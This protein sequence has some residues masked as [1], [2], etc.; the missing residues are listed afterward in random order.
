MMLPCARRADQ[1]VERTIERSRDAV[2][3]IEAVRWSPS[4]TARSVVIE[5]GDV[6]SMS[7]RGLD[8]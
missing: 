3:V 8:D 4:P 5:R 7:E 2:K 6:T 1:I